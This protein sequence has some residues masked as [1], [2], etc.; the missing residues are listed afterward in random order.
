MLKVDRKKLKRIAQKFGLKLI[1]AFGSQVKGNIHSES[2]LDIGVLPLKDISSF[3][4]HFNLLSNLRKVFSDYE[5]DVVFINRAD[6]LLLKKMVESALLLYGKKRDFL[7]FK[8]YAFNRFEDYKPFF[9][10]EEKMVDDFIERLQY[11]H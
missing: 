1:I 4:E 2:D 8:I 3:D 6:P 9:R 10:L 11:A 7:E 5:I